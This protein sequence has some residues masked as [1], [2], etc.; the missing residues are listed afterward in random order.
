[1]FH[2]G[3]SAFDKQIK[4]REMGICYLFKSEGNLC[5]SIF[6]QIYTGTL[7][8]VHNLS[9]FFDDGEWWIEWQ[10]YKQT[11]FSCLPMCT[12]QGQEKTGLK[13][14]YKK[15]NHN[16]YHWWQHSLTVFSY[17]IFSWTLFF[18]KQSH[19]LLALKLWLEPMVPLT[20]YSWP[21]SFH[22]VFIFLSVFELCFF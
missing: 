15:S 1:M 20:T 8:N 17:D 14:F 9:D 12:K 13:E 7:K 2:F 21:D 5:S 4:L 18:S 16:W 22:L 19:A 6:K 3:Y 10:V 11:L